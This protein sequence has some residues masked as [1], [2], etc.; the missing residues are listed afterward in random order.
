M[1][2]VF[3]LLDSYSS[4]ILDYLGPFKKMTI[5]KEQKDDVTLVV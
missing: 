3:N 4:L 2:S 1:D 5:L